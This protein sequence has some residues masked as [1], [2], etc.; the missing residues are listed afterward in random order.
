MK[1][2]LTNW[3]AGFPVTTL[4]DREAQVIQGTGEGKTRVKLYFD[5]ES[6]PRRTPRSTPPSSRSPRLR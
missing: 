4:E 1:D 5:K 6:G 3:R 2:A